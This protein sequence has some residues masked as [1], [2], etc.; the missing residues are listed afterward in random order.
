MSKI[1]EIFG[2]D[3]HAMTVSLM[4]AA[5]VVSVIPKNASVALKPNLVLAASPENGATTHP[6]VLSG[7]IEYL[8]SNGFVDIS[9]MESSWVGAGTAES[10]HAAGYDEICS[11]YNVPFYDLKKDS[12]VSLPTPF[13]PIDVSKRAAS[14]DFLI[15]LPV[16]KGHCQTNMTCAL[17]NLKGCLPDREK[18]KFHSDGLIK[19]IAALGA[20]LKPSLIIVDSI[21]GDLNFEE[22]GNPVE[23]NRMFLGFDA[24]QIDTYGCQ[25]MG[26]SLEDVPYI[27]L[28]ESWGAGSTDLLPGDI[29]RL[30]APEDG[31]VYPEPSGLVKQLTRNVHADQACSSCFAALVR[32]L[33]QIKDAG[34]AVDHEIFIGQGWRERAVSGFGC[35]NCCRSAPCGVKGCPPSSSAIIEALKQTK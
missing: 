31:S 6:G 24:V 19:P 4:E 15:D 35:G 28:A 7:C 34:V 25:L 16:F 21:C 23:T 30:N 29:I 12:T 9:I 11:V 14:S 5:D 10:F 8:Q 3:A 1:Y 17:K 13:R 2:S 33:Y 20:A 27:S 18:R 22:G 32:A 26:L